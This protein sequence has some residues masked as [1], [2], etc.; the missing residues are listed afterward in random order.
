METIELKN[1]PWN[2]Y[3]SR[4]YL[5][6]SEANIYVSFDSRKLLKKFKKCILINSLENKSKKLLQLS[7]ISDLQ[8]I[9]PNINSFLYDE[10]QFIGYIMDYYKGYPLDELMLTFEEKVILLKDL[11][12]KIL[13][14]KNKNIYYFDLHFDN[15]LCFKQED[16]LETK[17]IDIDNIQINHY[18]CDTISFLLEEY[19]KLGGKIDQNALIYIFNMMSY[20]LLVNCYQ[21]E[22]NCLK[23]NSKQTFLDKKVQDICNDLLTSHMDSLCDHEFL[24]DFI[25]HDDYGNK[26]L[27]K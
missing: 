9:Y 24:I 22:I 13:R 6:G 17:L 8:D 16:T 15:I 10:D 19:L 12:E 25:E 3:R 5:D 26:I 27:L 20:S 23:E 4:S 18:K 1:F 7:E 11:K 14:L 21:L 2:E